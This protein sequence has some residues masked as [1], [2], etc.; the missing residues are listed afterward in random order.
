VEFDTDVHPPIE[1][2]AISSGRI[3]GSSMQST[4]EGQRAQIATEPAALGVHTLMGGRRPE[5]VRN[6]SEAISDGRI[7]PVEIIARKL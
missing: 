7:A 1:L 4:A 2:A 5:M 6:M 3:P